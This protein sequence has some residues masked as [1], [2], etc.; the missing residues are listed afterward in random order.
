MKDKGLKKESGCSWIEV[1]KK[2]HSF[3]ADDNAHRHGDGVHEVVN[4]LTN[5]M[6]DAGYAPDAGFTALCKV[7][8]EDTG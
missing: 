5:K 7:S 4:G 8:W 1:K 2:V 3:I 6:F